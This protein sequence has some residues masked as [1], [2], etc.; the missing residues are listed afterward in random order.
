VAPT[1]V[2]TLIGAAIAAKIAAAMVGRFI[3]FPCDYFVFEL[4]A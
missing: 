3:V 4:S 2:T 1:G